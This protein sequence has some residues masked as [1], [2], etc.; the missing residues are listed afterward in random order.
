MTTMSKAV[1]LAYAA[2]LVVAAIPA[3]LWAQRD[4]VDLS[5]PTQL[6]RN[7]IPRHYAITVTP[8]AAKLAFTGQVAIDLTVAEATR[9]LTLNAADLAVRKVTISAAASGPAVAGAASFDAAAQTLTIDFGRELAPGQYRL[10]I[11]YSGKINRQAN[12]L[13]ALDYTDVDGKP[14]R[15]LFTQFE[16]PDAR[17]FVPSWDE[18]DYRATF[19]LAVRLPAG[20]LA[21]SNM[22]EAS[23]NAIGGGLKEVRFARSP[24]MSTYLL[25]L[26]TGDLERISKKVGDREVGIVASRGNIE[27]A[28]YALDA[29][30]QI[31]PYFDDYFGTPYPLP[32]LDNVAGPGQSQFFGAME[33][34]GAI[35]SF[36]KLLL[37]DP[38][39]S[40]ESDRQAIFSVEAHEMAH[41]WFGNLVT[42]AWWDDL[43]LNEGFASWMAN[44]TT[45]HFNPD[46]GADV[47]QVEDRETAMALDG[48]AATHPIVQSIRTVEQINQAFDDITYQKGQ[49]V[50]AMLERFAGEDV[51]RK[52]IRSY[53]AKHAYQNTRTEDLW[54]AMEQAGAVGMVAVARDFT[55]Q[56]GIPLIKVGPARCANGTSSATVRQ[57]Q[58]SL[59]RRDAVAAKPLSWR[60]PVRASAGGAVS[61]PVLTQNGTAQ[62]TADG[63]GPLIVNPGQVG[64]YRV[65]YPQQD[66]RALVGK[67][68][69]LSSVDQYG[70]LSDQMA[71]SRAGYQPMAAGLDVLAAVPAAASAKVAANALVQWK[72]LYD[73][74]ADDPASQAAISKL[75]LER[76]GPRLRQL[77]FSP[78]AG[79]P[80]LDASLRPALIESLGHLGSP[81]VKAEG[82]RLL[83]ALRNDP[84]AIPGSLKAT[85][86]GVLGRN[87]DAATWDS[88]RALARS[89][90][91][92]VERITFYDALGKPRDEA[93]ARRALDLALSSEPG[94]TVSPGIISAVAAEHPKLALDYILARL[95]QFEP[96]VDL[97][98]RSRFIARM[99]AASG[100]EEVARTLEAYAEANVAATD[101]RPVDEALGKI[102][103]RVESSPRI[104]RET[105]AWLKAR[106]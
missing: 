88:L 13:F 64:Y 65:L 37:L 36:E 14:A 106:K 67:Y 56:P 41:Q 77:G 101:R 48:F 27:K 45:Q 58:F 70:L 55:M 96:L 83:A 9:T 59:D 61:E 6:P 40:S 57:S 20:Q 33:N 39:I 38:A 49:S 60:V 91:G 98:A 78:R 103:W 53:I 74:L 80:A 23:S 66:L 3:P 46:W 90:K 43:W 15:A 1:F 84:G 10:Q 85:W 32:K 11:D 82:E 4:T 44:K 7:A 95:K 73:V 87:A 24:E 30:A 75:A 18:P 52:G 100:D 2:A 47:E 25:F 54:R 69:T 5:L 28:R 63:C 72:A 76:F 42:M 62:V 92:T 31:L 22:P 29:E 21:V 79:E 97:S 71:L 94:P 68:P 99:V 17:R 105:A 104:A 102:R 19:D 12:G 81:E 86:L 93:L 16:A 50:I 35:F 89:T 8:D 34:W 51:W 26:A